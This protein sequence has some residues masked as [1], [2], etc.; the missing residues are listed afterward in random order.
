[1]NSCSLNRLLL[2]CL[3]VAWSTECGQKVT[4]T[5]DPSFDF[6]R[7]KRYAWLENRLVTRQHPDT[8]K[9]MDLKIVK[10]VN[11]IL[12][13]KGFVEVSNQPE[14]Y[15][16]YDG[17]GESDLDAAPVARVNS[18]PSQP[19]DSTPTYGLGNGPAMAPATWLKVDGRISFRMTDA[20]SKRQVWSST[21]AKTFRDPE[22]ALRNMDKEV[23]ELVTKSFVNFPP[24]PKR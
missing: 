2:V 17:G 5:S 24:K 19:N 16:L 8:N 22:K 23:N 10:A 1:M 3:V 4:T 13:A 20:A 9:V 14:F 12:T 18:A 6:A 11:R 7:Y 21:Y 15:V